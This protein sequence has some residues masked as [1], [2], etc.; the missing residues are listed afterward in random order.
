VTKDP[1]LREASKPEDLNLF[2][3]FDSGI[4]A[5]VANKLDFIDAHEKIPG[6]AKM[7]VSRPDFERAD[8]AGVQMQLSRTSL[9]SAT[10]GTGFH[11]SLRGY[12][13]RSTGSTFRTFRWT[14]TATF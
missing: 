10:T 8:A 3:Y 12:Q 5:E 2:W 6:N 11:L 7:T 9:D 14:V 4:K 1:A 13:A